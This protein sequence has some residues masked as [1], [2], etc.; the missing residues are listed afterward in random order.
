MA[1]GIVSLAGAL[2]AAVWF[3]VERELFAI[4]VGVG[5]AL[6]AVMMVAFG[7]DVTRRWLD[8]GARLGFSPGARRPFLDFGTDRPVLHGRAGTHPA[9]LRLVLTR[10]PEGRR[11]WLEVETDLLLDGADPRALAARAHMAAREVAPVARVQVRDGRL[12][13]RA[14]LTAEEGARALVDGLARVADAVE[15]P[16]S[17]A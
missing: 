16:G 4:L 6:F 15:K 13:M 14:P 2:T 3:H 8:Y 7:R 9:R 12:A 1:A 11:E 10:G 17:S 5:I